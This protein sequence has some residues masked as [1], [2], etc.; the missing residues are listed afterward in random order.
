[1]T[2]IYGWSQANVREIK[3]FRYPVTSCTT[4]Q[5]PAH[6]HAES[7]NESMEIIL[8]ESNGK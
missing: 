4:L 5:M 3:Y 2:Q 8:K 6:S 7:E 1:M